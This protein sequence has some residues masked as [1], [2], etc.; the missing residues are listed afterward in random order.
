MALTVYQYPV[1]SPRPRPSPGVEN[2]LHGATMETGSWALAPM[3]TRTLHTKYT[4]QLWS[5][6]R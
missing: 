5:L 1:L 2:C 6:S 4:L 3:E